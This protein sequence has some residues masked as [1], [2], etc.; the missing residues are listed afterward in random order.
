MHQQLFNAFAVLVDDHQLVVAK[1]D[2]AF[3]KLTRLFPE[4]FAVA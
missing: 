2:A 3:Q 4:Q 1:T